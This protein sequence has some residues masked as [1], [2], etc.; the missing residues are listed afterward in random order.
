MFHVNA[1]FS[2]AGTAA[3]NARGVNLADDASKHLLL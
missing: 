1:N 2:A 3:G